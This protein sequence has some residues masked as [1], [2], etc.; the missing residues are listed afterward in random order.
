MMASQFS[1]PYPTVEESVLKQSINAAHQDRTTDQDVPCVPTLLAKAQ[2]T[3]QLLLSALR[4]LNTVLND[5]ECVDVNDA[6]GIDQPHASLTQEIEL[7]HM[8][9][10]SLLDR[11]G[12]L[13]RR[14]GQL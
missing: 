10:D 13:Q 1:V 14:V 7:T 5:Q 12:D 2:R 3:R 11:I 4:D 6:R 8:L 9:V